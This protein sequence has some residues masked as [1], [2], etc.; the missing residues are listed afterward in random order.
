MTWLI[1]R[2]GISPLENWAQSGGYLFATQGWARLLETLGASSGFAWSAK[3]ELG[4]ILPVFSKFSFRLGF[5]GFPQ[6]ALPCEV[7]IE[8]VATAVLPRQ[9]HLDLARL[10]ADAQADLLNHPTSAR[11]E[12]W[13]DDLPNWRPTGK[14]LKKD[15]AFARRKSSTQL[16]LVSGCPAPIVFH[17]L[18]SQTVRRNG[19]IARYGASYFQAITDLAHDNPLLQVF[20]VVDTNN[21]L[22]GAAVVAR[23]GPRA[24]YLHGAVNNYAKSLG[25]SD[26]LLFRLIEHAQAWGCQKF[27]LMASPWDQTGLHRYKLK[28]GKTQA[29]TKTWD[30][31]LSSCGQALAMWTRL[32]GR[33]DRQRAASFLSGQ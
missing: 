14:R 12:V 7:G 26:E 11:H 1:E 17:Q 9:W 27:S 32:R 22:V 21:L 4:F 18:Y 6:L 30:I 25:A 28:W 8:S 20:S 13:I 16:R 23:H 31:P 29:L 2:Q 33:H 5:L 19:G 24:Y 3:N 15:L 10:N